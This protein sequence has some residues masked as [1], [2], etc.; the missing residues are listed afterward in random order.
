MALS[1]P[2]QA[3]L[4]EASPQSSGGHLFDPWGYCSYKRFREKPATR[5]A[6]V[7]GV[8]SGVPWPVSQTPIRKGLLRCGEKRSQ[9]RGSGGGS[10]PPLPSTQAP[11]C[12]PLLLVLKVTWKRRPKEVPFPQQSQLQ[13]G[14]LLL[15]AGPAAQGLYC[16]HP[17][18]RSLG[19][20]FSGSLLTQG[21]R[22][23]KQL[24]H[25]QKRK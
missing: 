22:A 17:T 5:A 19:A 10:Q 13:G 8:Q 24:V 16:P 25:I 14:A 4:T 2:P 3:Y 9:E 23:G 11:L 20:I 15:Q 1:L 6:S 21:L 12:L 18:G 7:P